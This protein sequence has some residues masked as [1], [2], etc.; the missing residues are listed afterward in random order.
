M[1]SWT[2]PKASI[3]LIVPELSP[4]SR[5]G[6]PGPSRTAVMMSFFATCAGQSL[7]VRVETDLRCSASPRP[8]PHH[9]NSQ[10]D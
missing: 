4:M 2:A 1:E 9:Q 7:L 8:R 10:I 6:L 5:A 3:D